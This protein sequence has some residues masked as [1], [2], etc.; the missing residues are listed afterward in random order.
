MVKIIGP[1]QGDLTTIL[2]PEVKI[3][4]IVCFFRL[5]KGLQCNHDPNKKQSIFVLYTDP[6]LHA[7][8]YE[9]HKETERSRAEAEF[10]FTWFQHTL[11]YYKYTHILG[12]SMSKRVQRAENKAEFNLDFLPVIVSGILAILI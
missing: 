9:C 5:R 7:T 3:C 2:G 1:R 8:L 10:P 11:L 12:A 4:G 6:Y